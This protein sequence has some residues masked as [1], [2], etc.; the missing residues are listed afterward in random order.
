MA[1]GEA[2]EAWIGRCIFQPE[3]AGD[4][5]DASAGTGEP[6]YQI[7][8][9]L[10]RRGEE[11]RLA[12]RRQRFAILNGGVLQCADPP[13]DAEALGDRVAAP[14]IAGQDAQLS[15]GMIRQYAGGFDS[16]IAGGAD[17]R[18]GRSMHSLHTYATG[19]GGA[20]GSTEPRKS[21]SALRPCE[22]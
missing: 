14:S 19:P 16:G 4:I 2:V 6:G 13:L 11:D 22:L 3:R 1:V 17:D 20:R 21:I 7:Q 18:D 15:P 12:F 5:Y 10:G 9:D 8:R